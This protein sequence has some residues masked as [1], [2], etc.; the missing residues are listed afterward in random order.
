MSVLP[1]GATVKRAA[2]LV[3]AAVA[4]A[5]LGGCGAAQQIVSSRDDYRLYR[6]TRIAV[7]LEARLAAGNRYLKVAPHG[8]YA[9]EVR[10]WFGPAERGYVAKAQ[11]SL[12]RLRA[13]LAALPDGPS[14]PEVRSRADE[15]KMVIERR[16]RFEAAQN[17][18]NAELS[19]ALERA[20]RQRKEFVREA[21]RWTAELMQ[22]RSFGRPLAELSPAL[23]E[24]MG[25]A[26]PAN[27]CMA[28]ICSK[29]VDTRFAVPQS[30]PNSAGRL[31]PRDASFS[32]ELSFEKE[33]LSGARLRGRELFSRI[34]EA[35]DLRPVSFAD[36]QGRAEAIGRAL[37]LI[38][39]VLPP[40]LSAE[41]C[42][43]PAVSPIV[44][45]RVCA[46]VRLSVTAGLAAGDDDIVMLEPSPAARSKKSR[47]QPP[48]SAP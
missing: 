37:A 18:K 40:A 20:A 48:K 23:V 13:Y 35:F 24:G 21:T 34:G 3:I 12:P 6:Q 29:F 11:D 7:T 47:P 14:A 28:G 17:A 33:R 19:T 10:E 42:E 27:V 46:G 26:D 8:A 9:E 4:G 30:A 44:L 15:L 31:L 16:K 41:G 5:G 22:V 36:P 1:R 25:L 38:G 45:E 43:R 32:V 39:N 2:L